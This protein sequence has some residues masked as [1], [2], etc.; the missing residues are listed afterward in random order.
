[1]PERLVEKQGAE[2]L[3]TDALARRPVGQEPEANLDEDVRGRAYL[4][5][6]SR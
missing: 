2:G 1:M 3:P 4:L 5:W 6:A